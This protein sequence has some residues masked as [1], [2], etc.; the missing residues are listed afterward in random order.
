MSSFDANDV[1]DRFSDDFVTPNPGLSTRENGVTTFHLKKGDIHGITTMMY[2]IHDEYPCISDNFVNFMVA[3]SSIIALMRYGYHG[4][5]PARSKVVEIELHS[6]ECANS[7][8]DPRDKLAYILS[9][10][11]HVMYCQLSNAFRN[12]RD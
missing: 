10:D 12:I 5:S 4:I 6:Q 1:F 3:L 11:N 9:N 2:I 7:F 8:K